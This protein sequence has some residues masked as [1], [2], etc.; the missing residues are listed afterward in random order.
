MPLNSDLP[1]LDE[2]QFIYLV[3]GTILTLSFEDGVQSGKGCYA[4]GSA[5]L[6]EGIYKALLYK[7]EHQGSHFNAAVLMQS[8]SLRECLELA[9]DAS[10]PLENLKQ[11]QRY[12]LHLYGFAQPVFSFSTQDLE[13]TPKVQ[14][15]HFFYKTELVKTMIY[16]S[17]FKPFRQ[18]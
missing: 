17:G 10:I 4:H 2:T 7:K 13:I 18:G 12:L 1:E 6:L 14:E 11:L 16:V 3:K 9:S 5:N 15:Q 8:L